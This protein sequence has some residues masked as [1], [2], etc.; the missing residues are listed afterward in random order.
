[1]PNP[2]RQLPEFYQLL[3]HGAMGMT[4][5]ILCA[6]ILL[7]AHV[8]VTTHV[9]DQPI[10]MLARFIFLVT[11]GLSF[12]IGAALTGAMFLAGEQSGPAIERP[13]RSTLDSMAR[14]QKQAR[15]V[16]KRAT[17]YRNGP[18]WGVGI[19]VLTIV[20]VTIAWG[21]W[22]GGGHD[23]AGMQIS[24]PPE[25]GS[26]ADPTSMAADR[27][28]AASNAPGSTAYG[29]GAHQVVFGDIRRPAEPRRRSSRL[30][31]TVQ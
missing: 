22:A 11:V 28:S 2:R 25:V 9:V 1:M 13:S 14:K 3:W 27:I 15:D 7:V 8:P 16:A 12:G 29:T 10:S 31:D 4:L 20:I 18:G 24:V 19:L 6:G 21:S 30:T 26:A 23:S 5:G 17:P